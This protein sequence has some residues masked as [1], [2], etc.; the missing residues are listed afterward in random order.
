MSLKGPLADEEDMPRRGMVWLIIRLLL[1]GLNAG[2][3]LAV[4]FK[5]IKLV[6]GVTTRFVQNCTLRQAGQ[7][8]GDD[9]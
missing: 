6:V 3:F 5:L 7:V 9:S 2:D 4:V 1:A 8:M